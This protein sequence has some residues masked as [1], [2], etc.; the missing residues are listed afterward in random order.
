MDIKKHHKTGWWLWIFSMFPPKKIMASWPFHW[1]DSRSVTMGSGD[2]ESQIRR[3]LIRWFCAWFTVNT[4][5]YIYIYI[6]YKI[7]YIIY[8]Y[9]ILYICIVHIYIYTYYISL[10]DRVP[11]YSYI[12]PFIIFGITPNFFSSTPCR[13]RLAFHL[14]WRCSFRMNL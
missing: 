3:V 1:D 5:I 6:L 12:D 13:R 11:E 10:S 4:Y 9:K 8:I 14:H 2:G 7:L